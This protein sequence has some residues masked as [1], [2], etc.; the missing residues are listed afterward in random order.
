MKN[1]VNI[2][3]TYT[4]TPC[5][6]NIVRTISFAS[7]KMLEPA[8]PEHLTQERTIPASTAESYV[9]PFPAYCARFPRSTKDHVMAVVGAQYA[10]AAGNDGVA[11]A[12]LSEFM[13]AKNNDNGDGNIRPSAWEVVSVTDN[14]G[15][16]NVAIIAYWPNKES[17]TAWAE[18]SGFGKWWEALDA[19]SEQHGWFLEVFFPSIERYETV[20]SD[21]SVPEGAAHM[22]ERISGMIKEHACWGSM[23]DRLPASQTDALAGEK[24]Q[25]RP[26]KQLGARPRHRVRVPGKHN[27]AVIRSGQDWANTYPEERKLYIETMHPVLITGMDYL[28]DHGE[29][30]GCYSCR[31][32]DVVD[33]LSHEANTDKTFGLAYFNDL[34]SLEGWSK[35]HKTHLDIFGGFLAYAKRLDN[36]VSLRLYHEVFVLAPEQ[37]FFEYVGCHE[38]SGMLA[39]C[40]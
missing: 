39:S 21:N 9:P 24:G 32:M 20:F 23:R 8:I 12:C 34:A 13:K 30:V 38:D 4:S 6:A 11:I 7:E 1:I 2:Q 19:E 17:Y 26:R 28:R 10:S 31:F 40:S 5:L 27:L 25:I 36:N 35:R 15:A 3:H 29:E 22:Q 37:Q 18:G 14:T 16:Y 33:P